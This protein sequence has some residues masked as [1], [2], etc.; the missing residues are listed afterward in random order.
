MKE[1]KSLCILTKIPTPHFEEP[2]HR[3]AS[4]RALPLSTP[5]LSYAAS[6]PGG[7]LTGGGSRWEACRRPWASRSAWRTGWGVRRRPSQ[8]REKKQKKNSVGSI[9]NYLF[10]YFREEYC[11][12][13]S[14]VC[15][16]R[17][18]R[19]RCPRRGIPLPPPLRR[20]ACIGT[21]PER[22]GGPRDTNRGGIKLQY[23]SSRECAFFTILPLNHF[24]SPLGPFLGCRGDWL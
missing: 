5:I 6:R 20:A 19:F 3:R 2:F 17:E 4:D 12:Y 10:P 9:S 18:V 16:P 14:T 11:K 22:K 15:Q 21:N 13:F 23:S 1:K 7:R 8:R 24:S